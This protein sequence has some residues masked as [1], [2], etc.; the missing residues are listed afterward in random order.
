MWYIAVFGILI[1]VIFI[2]FK[3]IKR[4]IKYHKY[5]GITNEVITLAGVALRVMYEES[6]S[7]EFFDIYIEPVAYD[8][9][10]NG[11]KYTSKSGNLMLSLSCHYNEYV[12]K[13]VFP[14]VLALDYEGDKVEDFLYFVKDSG[15]RGYLRALTNN[16]FNCSSE[17]MAKMAYTAL[18]KHFPK[19]YIYIAGHSVVIEKFKGKPKSKIN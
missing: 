15:S 9:N 10:Y 6:V 5:K 19:Q 18:K 12:T 1:I 8:D 17:K 3:L 13:Y 14:Q 2:L 7:K 11:Y 4:S 16:P